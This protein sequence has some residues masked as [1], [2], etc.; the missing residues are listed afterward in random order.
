MKRIL[1]VLALSFSLVLLTAA[2]NDRYENLGGKIMCS[3]G[4]NQML[5]KCNHVGCPDS[6]RMIR[7]LKAEV[8]NPSNSDED[9]LYWFRKTYGMTVVVEPAA[10]GF[11]LTIWVVPPILVGATFLLVVILIRRWRMR[12]AALQVTEFAGNPQL[13]AY[14]N[15]AR[16]ETEL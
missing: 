12:A 16:K 9:V 6:D 4:C 14:R 1:P 10:H 11:E 8:G 2:G 5:L 3:C 7:E 15:R 13:D